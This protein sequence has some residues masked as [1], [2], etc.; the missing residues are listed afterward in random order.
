MAQFNNSFAIVMKGDSE[1][2]FVMFSSFVTLIVLE[3][4]AELTDT[5]LQYL[6]RGSFP[7]TCV[8][9]EVNGVDGNGVP[10]ELGV[11]ILVFLL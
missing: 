8:E 1:T 6:S 4:L 7:L 9:L 3:G 5:D 11:V 2:A 10:H